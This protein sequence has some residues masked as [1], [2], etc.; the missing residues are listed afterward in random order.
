LLFFS[1]SQFATR[2]TQTFL[3]NTG[4]I[5]VQKHFPRQ[6]P[7]KPW[8]KHTFSDQYQYNKYHYLINLNK[9]HSKY[10]FLIAPFG[11]PFC[12]F[13]GPLL[14]GG[15]G[16]IASPPLGGPGHHVNMVTTLVPEALYEAKETRGKNGGPRASGHIGCKS[17]F[18][19]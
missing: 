3:T 8:V 9:K 13:R 11:A 10:F 1:I 14:T 18:H 17:H 7:V 2:F 19:T 16:Q 6:I 4:K 12:K 15:P 5:K